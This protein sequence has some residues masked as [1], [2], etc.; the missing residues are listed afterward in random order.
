M[1]SLLTV[2]VLIGGVHGAVQA[3]HVFRCGATFSQH[4]CNAQPIDTSDA[5]PMLR[6]NETMQQFAERQLRHLEERARPSSTKV[7]TSV[8]D[9]RPR[10]P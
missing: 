10:Q 5:R 7:A 4:P 8:A 6:D 3:Q 2:L 1:K 9:K